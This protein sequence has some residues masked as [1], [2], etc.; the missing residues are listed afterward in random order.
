MIKDKITLKRIQKLHPNIRNYVLIIYNEI[1]KTGISIRI[2]NTLRTFKEQ[3]DLYALGRTKPGKIVTHAK[4]GESYHNYGLAIDF[5]LLI[6]NKEVSWNRDLDL[7][8][9][10]Q[11]DWDQVVKIFK[12]YGWV[13]GGDF[14]R[15]KDYP[16]FQKT[17]DFSI[18]QLQKL[19][20]IGH[21]K[22]GYLII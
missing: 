18:K 12:K 3:D 13:W 1:L 17:F 4:G 14:H 7:N 22:E 11:K 10:G 9:D 6:S 15:F 5:C 16:H 20:Q 2:T 8:N 19:H 21:I